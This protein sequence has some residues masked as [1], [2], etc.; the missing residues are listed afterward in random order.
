[1]VKQVEKRGKHR[2][3][4]RQKLKRYRVGKEECEKRKIN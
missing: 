3:N 4:R 1:M 2:N